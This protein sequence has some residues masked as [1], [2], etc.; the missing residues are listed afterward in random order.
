MKTPT[1]F[2]VDDDEAVRDSIAELV[3][4]VG[5]TA[6]TFGSAQVQHEAAWLLGIEPVEE[7]L[8]AREGEGGQS[9]RT[10]QFR[11]GVTHGLVVVDDE[12]GRSLQ[13]SSSSSAIGNV[14]SNAAPPPG[15]GTYR[16]RPPCDSTMER[17][18]ASPMPR[19]V[20]FVE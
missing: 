5:L 16:S 10:H 19:P 15:F 13:G 12:Y 4:S 1:V 9:H 14:N 11:D 7:L 20:A 8:C 6:V 2:I 17:Q 18:T 3:S